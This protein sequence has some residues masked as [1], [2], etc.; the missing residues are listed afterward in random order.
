MPKL[1]NTSHR[2]EFLFLGY[3][4]FSRALNLVPGTGL[5]TVRAVLE[6]K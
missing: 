1:T 2:M 3:H 4:T 6:K 5:S